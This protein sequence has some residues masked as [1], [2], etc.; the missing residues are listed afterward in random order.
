MG[1][2][3]GGLRP[4]PGGGAGGRQGGG[5]GD[6]ESGEGY[7]DR[8]EEGR[9]ELR[10]VPRGLRQGRRTRGSGAASAEAGQLDVGGGPEGD[11]RRDLLEN[12]ERSWRHAPVE[13]PP[14][15]GALGDA[16]V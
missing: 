5:H 12:V 10:L 4:G 1:R 3:D 16:R 7:R 14:G 2:R 11:R 6:E 8:K 9:D 15:A 13:A